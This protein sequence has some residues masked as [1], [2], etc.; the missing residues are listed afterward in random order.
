[1]ANITK[2]KPH[3]ALKR[4]FS[5]WGLMLPSLVLF[6]F[7]LWLPLAESLRLS[8]Y[9]T[10]GMTTEKFVLFQNYISVFKSPD[11][12]PALKNTFTY[13]LFSLIIGF[14]IPIIMALFIN[15]TVRAK[16]IFR[17]STYTPNI[18]PGLA[19]T[20]MWLY[21]FSP[22]QTGALNLLVKLF[23]L[24]ASQWLGDPHLTIVLI[25]ITLTWKGAGATALIYLAGI[26]SI[27]REQFEAAVIDGAGIFA[28]VR[29]ITAPGIYNLAR[30]LLILQIISVFQI[31]YEPLVMTNGGPNDASISLMQLVYRYAFDKFQYDK[32]SAVSAI[33]FAL[34]LILTFAHNKL[35]KE[36][37]A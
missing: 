4:N 35:I 16:G 21:I 1:M 25:V 31:M 28:R 12:L 37:E 10:R 19:T 36:K 33:I 18:V 13:T 27:S 15:E 5:G 24:P 3:N 26:S 14:F 2:P 20:F 17:V 7:F 23:G 29:Y 9:H 30:T 6:A 34:L 11:F 8:V 32:A 22:S